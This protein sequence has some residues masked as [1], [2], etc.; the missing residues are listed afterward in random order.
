MLP[1]QQPISGDGENYENKEIL[2]KSILMAL[3]NFYKAFNNKDLS[4]MQK[5][6]LNSENIAM[7][8]P[9]G[10]IKRGWNSIEDVYKKIFFGQ[11]KVYVEFYDYTIQLFENGFCVIGRER[12]VVEFKGKKL[13]LAIRTSRIYTLENGIYKQIHH[14]G[15]IENPELLKDYQELVFLK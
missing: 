7:S 11:V 10:G 2:N 14:H 5:N 15:S 13:D 4:L 1:I 9:L 6:W 3:H 8:N 12:G